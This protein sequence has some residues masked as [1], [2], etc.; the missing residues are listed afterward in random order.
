VVTPKTKM[1]ILEYNYFHISSPK[2][3]RISLLSS[4]SEGIKIMNVGTWYI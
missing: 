1:K 2:G 4:L 3:K